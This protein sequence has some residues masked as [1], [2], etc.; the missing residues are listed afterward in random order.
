MVAGGE[1]FADF[2]T[3]DPAVISEFSLYLSIAAWGYAGFGLLI[4]ANGILNA[5]DKAS[6]ALMQSVARVFLI[7]LPFAL[8]FSL[9]W[10]SSAI[11]AAEL[12]ANIFGAVTAVLIVS[13]VL[14]RRD[15]L[16]ATA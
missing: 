1:W 11:Y 7:M 15:N 10:G 8:Y 6:F 9:T 13:I 16:I 2:F 3:K 12:A 14:R 5:V 4:V